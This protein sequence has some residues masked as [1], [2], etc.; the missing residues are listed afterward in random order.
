M[1][2]SFVVQLRSRSILTRKPKQRMIAWRG[3]LRL[4]SFVH[5][6]ITHITTFVLLLH[7]T[8]GCCMHHVHACEAACCETP[9]A[10][11]EAC[12]C[13][14]HPHDEEVTSDESSSNDQGNDRQHENS[15][16]GGKC[17]FMQSKTQT[18]VF[19]E[20]DRGNVVLTVLREPEGLSIPMAAFDLLR[21]FRHA[22]T[23]P[24]LRTHLLYQVLLI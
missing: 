20:M 13:G 14:S 3:F 22:S 6:T 15:C 23:G 16:D 21:E 12:P 9:V 11:A 1:I 10:A 24:P 18:D 5:P 4:E 19:G 8:Q 2:R 17:V 7:I